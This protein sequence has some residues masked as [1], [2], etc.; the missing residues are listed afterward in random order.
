MNF[1]PLITSG[2]TNTPLYRLFPHPL[3]Y[4]VVSNK[5][6]VVPQE[7]KT[8]PKLSRIRSFV[9]PKD[10]TKCYCMLLLIAHSGERLKLL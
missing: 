5:Y 3:A 8:Q 4:A 10:Q 9:Y 7:Q 1:L 2:N 6:E